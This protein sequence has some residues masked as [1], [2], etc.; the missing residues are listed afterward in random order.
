MKKYTVEIDDGLSRV[1]KE[2][3]SY[4]RASTEDIMQSILRNAIRTIMRPDPSDS[5]ARVDLRKS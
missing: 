1:Y 2:I 5:S 3:A 4:N